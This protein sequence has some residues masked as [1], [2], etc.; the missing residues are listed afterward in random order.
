ALRFAL[1]VLVLKSS[2]ASRALID[3]GR[4]LS[5]A[6][7][8]SE[9]AARPCLQALC[10]RDPAAL[11]A[12]GLA[13]AGIESVAENLSDSVVAPLFY[14]VLFGLPGAVFYRV[15]NTLDAMV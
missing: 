2:F 12:E 8:E 7:K 10:S 14:F 6:L 4:A 3:A 15:V 11:D 9:A 5:V 1:I 13:A